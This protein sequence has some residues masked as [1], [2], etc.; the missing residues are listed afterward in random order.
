MDTFSGSGIE[1]HVLALHPGEYVME[2]VKAL[3]E[4]KGI[5]NGAVV[6]GMG[7]LDYC[8]MHMGG[9]EGIVMQTWDDTPLEFTGMQGVIADGKTGLLVKPD[10]PVA[11]AEAI[12]AV[13]ADPAAAA[14]RARAARA[15]VE[16]RFSHVA[17]VTRLLALYDD[18]I[19]GRGGERP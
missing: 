1:V 17:A 15:L 6:S 7:T 13:I 3:I 18:V 2:S 12:E 5:R 9:R 10:D 19:A 16:E 4:E 11:L 14:A 8:K